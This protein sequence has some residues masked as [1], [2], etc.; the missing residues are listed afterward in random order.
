MGQ[1]VRHQATKES[2]QKEPRHQ[3]SHNGDGG[4]HGPMELP[5]ETGG[6]DARNEAPIDAP[7]AATSEAPR[8]KGKNV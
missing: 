3:W 7:M 4:T 1:G 5:N 2:R 6:T 8:D